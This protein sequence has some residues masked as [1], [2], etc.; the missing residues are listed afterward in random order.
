M[1]EVIAKNRGAHV[2]R[3]RNH[4]CVNFS[5]KTLALALKHM[6]A[7]AAPVLE[8]EARGSQRKRSGGAVQCVFMRVYA[9]LC[10][11]A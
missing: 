9:C 5:G 4:S 3:K 10:V 7:L 2:A 1:R 11:Y 8:S 6:I